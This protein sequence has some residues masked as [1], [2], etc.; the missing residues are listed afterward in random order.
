MFKKIAVQLLGKK[1]GL[2]SLISEKTGKISFKRVGSTMVIAWIVN[3]VNPLEMTTA[4]AIVIGMC[5][6]SVSLPKVL[7]LLKKE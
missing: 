5:L 4:H 7:N 6:I 3:N 2:L 1:S